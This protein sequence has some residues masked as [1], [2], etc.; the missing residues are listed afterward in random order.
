MK[1]RIF[2]L[3]TFAIFFFQIANSQ[4]YNCDSNYPS[5]TASTTSST[6][7]T[8]ST[9]I[10]G[11]DYSYYNV[12]MGETYTWT[13]CGDSDFD[14]QLTL[15]NT[16][17]G[18][19]VLDYSDDDC[20]TQSTITW[21]ATYT[22]TVALL[23]SQYPCTTNTTSMT[24]QWACT[25][26][27]TTSDIL[28]TGCTGN[29]YDL[30]GA[31]GSYSNNESQTWTFCPDNPG[32]LIS[33]NF[34][35]WDVE[36][37][38]NWD[39]LLVYNGNSTAAPY[40]ITGDGLNTL[41]GVVQATPA[42]VSGCLTFEWSSDGSGTA[43][44]WAATIS[45]TNPCQDIIAVWNGS[46]PPAIYDAVD[47]SYYIDIC[48]GETVTF[49]AYGN[50]PE[51]GT[52]YTQ[53]DAT[54]T[55]S[56]NFDDG[57]TGTGTTVNHTYNTEGGFD[58]DLTITD[59][60][61][62]INA[63]DIGVR[64]RVSTTPIFAGTMSN[65]YSICVG[66][67][68]NLTGVVT[69]QLWQ[70]PSSQ[71]WAGTT[72]LPDGSGVSYTTGLTFDEF[73]P[74][75]TVTSIN[76]IDEICLNMEHS[77][78]GDLDVYIEC[79]NG[80]TTQL[81]DTYNGV[82]SS[83]YLGE[84]TDYSSNPGVG[85]DYCFSPTSTN[86]TFIDLI[87]GGAPTYSYVDADGNT[88]TSHAYIPAGTYEAEGNWAN[89]IGC[90]LNGTWTIHVTDH[91]S[92]DDGYI[93]SWGIGFDPSLYPTMW[94]FTPTVVSQSW[95][96][97]GVGA[98][99]PTT[100]C[101]TSTGN[102]SYVYSITDN[103]G[104]TYDTT[105]TITVSSLTITT[106]QVNV[107]CFGGSNGSATVTS[108]SGG[109]AP[110]SYTWSPNVS[111][112]NSATGL[113]AGT[114]SV[115]VNDATGCGAINSFTIT[116]P[117]AMSYSTSTTADNCGACDG[118]ATV[119]AVSGGTAPYT[120]LWQGG[121]TTSP[122]TNLC[123]G[124]Y[125]VVVT[126]AA[127][128]TIGN[129]ATVTGTGS[130]TAG[131]TYNGNQCL[132]GGANSYC[133]T[134]TGT[135]G[136]SYSWNF[137][138]GVGTSTAPNPCYSYTS[139]GTYTVTQTVIDGACTDVATMN[140][141]VYAHPTLTITV[142]D[143]TCNGS[144]NGTATATPS[145]GSG[146][147]NYQWA[148]GAGSQTTQTATALCAGTYGIT[149]NDTYGCSVT[150]SATISEPVGITLTASS[151]NVVCNGACDGTA[152]VIAAGGTGAYVYS[153]SNSGST[154]N[155]TGLCPGTYTVSVY[156]AADLT[157]FETETVVITEPAAMVLS[158]S[159]VDATC[160]MS[161]GS[162]TVSVTSGG[163]APFGYLW[164]AAAGGQTTATATNLAA[165]S[166]QVVVNDAVGCTATTTV[167]VNDAGSPTA[168][169][170]STTNVSCNGLCDGSATVTLGGTLNPDFD[171]LWSTGAS[172][173]NSVLTTNTINGLCAGS[174]TVTVT[175]VNG[176]VATATT[177]ITEAPALTATTTVTNANCGQPDGSATASASGGTGGYSYQWDAAAANQITATASNLSA[178]LY[179]VV[180]TDAAGCTFTV[181]AN[182][183]DIGGMTSITGTSANVLCN[184]GSTGTATATPVGGT[185]PYDYL[186]DSNAANQIT[187]TA[188]GLAANTYSV[189]VTDDNG[190]ILVGS[191]TV[192]Q[193][194]AV[195]A[196]ISAQTPALCNGQASGTATAA[197][198][199]GI[200]PYTYQWSGG[201]APTSQTNTGLAAGTYSVTVY[202]SNL[203][204]SITSVTI[205][206][207]T[208]INIT[209]TATDENCF[210]CNGAVATS[211]TGGTN[212]YSYAWSGLAA[213]Q[214]TPTASNLCSASYTVTVTDGNGCSAQATDVVTNIPAGTATISSFHNV[215]CNGLCDGD[216]TVS[217]GG[218]T[219][220]YSYIWSASAGSQ[221]GTN[222]INLCA[223]VHSVSVTDN[224]GCLVTVSV[225]IT[226]PLV[227]TTTSTVTDLNCFNVCEGSIVA[228]PSGGT[229]PYSYQ[230]D[231]MLITTPSATNL[232]AGSYTF[233]VTDNNGCSV[234][235]TQTV[236]NA[237]SIEITGIVTNANCGQADG[238]IDITVTGGTGPYTY[239][240]ITTSTPNLED[241]T[242]LAANT[243]TV[244]V[245]DSK[246]C[247]NQLTFTV[248][249]I[250]GPSASIGSFTNV[251]CNGDCDGTATV[252]PLG[253]SGMYGFQ[254]SASAGSQNTITATNLCAGIHNITVTD[255]S[256][257]C[258]ATSTVTITE[259]A[260]LAYT[261]TDTDPSCNAIYG[262]CNGEASV[263]V[264]GGTTPYSYLWTGPGLGAGNTN[265]S[266][267]SLCAGNYSL[268]VSDANGCNLMQNFTLV[269][270]PFIN[271]TFSTIDEQCSG[272]CDG[273]ALVIP[274]GGTGPG[275]TYQW[276]ANAENQTSANAVGLCAG[277]Y[278]VTVYDE[279]NCGQTGNVNVMTPNPMSFVS[280]VVTDVNCF[281][282][283]N[284][285]IAV[286]VT[287]G[288]PPYTYVWS[289]GSGS[290]NPS[291]LCQGVYNLTVYDD[292]G[293]FITTTAIVNQPPQLAM[294]LSVTDETC[295][296][297]NDGS[298]TNDI[299]GGQPPYNIIWMPGGLTT[300][301]II[302]LADGTYCVTVTDFNGCSLT[303][304]ET[305]DGPDPLEI[306]NIITQDAH[307]ENNDGSIQISIAGGIPSYNIEWETG[308]NSTLL[309]NIYSG[310][311]DVT[312]TDANS[313]EVDTTI[314][315]N[316]IDGPVINSLTSS[317]ITCFGYANGSA[318]VTYTAI[319]PETILW[320]SVPPQNAAT[321]SNLSP[322]TYT[323]EIIDGNGCNVSQT[324]NITQPNQLNASIGSYT[325]ALC[326]GDCN[327][328]ATVT[329][330]GG[331]APY[332]YDWPVSSETTQTANALCFGNHAVIVTDANGCTATDDQF[333]NQPNL[334]TVTPTI[335]NVTCNGSNNGIITI[336]SSGS[337]PTHTYNWLNTATSTSTDANLVPG[338]HTVCITD[339]LGCDTCLTYTITQP[340][341]I[342]ATL[343]STDATC[344]EPNG[345]IFVSTVSGGTS[346][347]NYS[348]S[349]A[350][351]VNA[352]GDVNS[353]APDGNYLV[354]IYD[355]NNCSEV[356]NG[357]ISEV[358]PPYI[359]KIDV[360]DVS[361]YGFND[362]WADAEIAGG[363]PPY[364]YL[365]L[366]YGGTEAI[367][368][369]LEA[370]SYTLFVT[371]ATGCE[372][373]QTILVQQPGPVTLT[374]TGATTICIGQTAVLNAFAN[375][376][377]TPY[378]YYW[379]GNPGGN[380]IVVNPDSLTCYSVS[381]LDANG[382]P[383]S[384][385]QQ[386]C[387]DVYPAITVNV[388]TNHPVI[389]EGESAILVASATGG[390]GG[391]Y[392]FY[393]NVSSENTS[394]IT[395]SPYDSTMYVV[396]ATDNC[397]SPSSTAMVPVKVEYPPYVNVIPDTSGCAPITV[398]FHNMVADDT[399][400]SYLWT[401]N[402]P[403]SGLSNVST[404]SD[405]THLF[406]NPGNYD[407]TLV[408]SSPNGCSTTI[409]YDN[410]VQVYPVPVADF[411]ADPYVTSLFHSR[412]EF[413]EQASEEVTSWIWSF[414]DGFVSNVTNPE[415]TYQ[416]PG[417]YDVLLV[418]STNH[419]CVDS[420]TKEI[421]ILEEVTFYAP[422]AITPGNGGRNQFFY[423]V[424]NGLEEE[425]FHMFI[426][427][428]WGEVIF[429]TTD[430]YE[431]W[432]GRYNGTGD[433]VELGT[434]TW[435]VNIMDVNGVQHE[436]VGAVTVIR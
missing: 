48:A 418:V 212:P 227:L 426:Y 78:V 343:A 391:P 199:G 139:T 284:G 268:L 396:Y 49:N 408:A 158:G 38:G 372:V 102:M 180:V 309:N 308:W 328:T 37:G 335:T 413:Y 422:N 28:I 417:T 104:C 368:N 169:I 128:C 201:T 97:N 105:I 315:I 229:I 73:N 194:S 319:A 161:N 198:A 136:V 60:T 242:G 5:G 427:D 282:N 179:W 403:A 277:N 165:G 378:T 241:Q 331:T 371:D 142:T 226:E 85:Y 326:N 182:V 174:I 289:N 367:A 405:P 151:S 302:N 50:Y 301:S 321:A 90:P 389:C 69:P 163:T 70:Y 59:I 176:C 219:A 395:V 213:G 187:Q 153:W 312:I 240:W 200:A 233:T 148:A 98:G 45:C 23:V 380:N 22:G 11:G 354:T 255:M 152:Q 75:Q 156:D 36:S 216:A 195:V 238:E 16:T 94:D 223:G 29:F 120:Y 61:G 436:Y 412:I 91:L 129:S 25:S 323:V 406:L 278:Q 246:S 210:Q 184:G 53:S 334:F 181:S 7:T 56:W 112:G 264:I 306:V 366:P 65:D 432:N 202:D 106:S 239:W 124:T 325:N 126:D 207:P 171:Y 81:F 320:N 346:P 261:I 382:C 280:V 95:S 411:H 317:N 381:V 172:T 359:S 364:T 286:N 252:S 9:I 398:T 314:C 115:T 12:T 218:G 420:I 88:V 108:A 305:V 288:T 281:G 322:G 294:T 352:E 430:F 63:N 292:N 234:S 18:G 299:I 351:T 30:G 149:V 3:L 254:W 262:A 66:E 330:G 164:N 228:N 347:Y 166:Y 160:G 109:T 67:C 342:T 72:F 425:T 332:S 311:Y 224:V 101:P 401:F 137:G 122:A 307:C 214:T 33:V 230:W 84:A 249:D 146:T 189:T 47:G 162:A 327:G 333:I 74:G 392:D 43:P 185:P 221:T 204:P 300:P 428:R 130:V 186:W 355:E 154:A 203:C 244:V 270:P 1:K 119:G 374:A 267:S 52:S 237:D 258:I 143:A 144:C 19:T 41:L 345:S 114:Y 357:T 110:Y 296:G 54:S 113:A 93:F 265:S 208:A 150:G 369:N 211:V 394:S 424:G 273:E 297:Y 251:S 34:T 247:T 133:F 197:G 159:S 17:C 20:G 373:N 100:A 135:S 173:N 225:T 386:V 14:T 131:F 409:T 40:M 433:Y 99:N 250:D 338:T 111:S 10:Y 155:I 356:F 170:S 206:E 209:T 313:C 316:N 134:N 141:T 80:Q 92:A 167:N 193:P 407:V 340:N 253:G 416:E 58:V 220:P 116:Q 414:G 44:G 175:D 375:G 365:W 361:C 421:I 266:V 348:W 83:E 31:A 349:P 410:L 68:A 168:S 107:S 117:A 423:V 32:S 276:D 393:W 362:G 419:N 303:A 140:V 363:T 287:G 82:G 318:T 125:S 6:L 57:A 291:G 4:C 127:G 191:V 377:S 339:N 77:Y 147:Y 157:C 231:G 118:T 353:N 329:V 121:Q 400:V 399:G 13:T 429:E 42:N 8:V 243:Y 132:N 274:S 269:E 341:P 188:S 344:E 236:N 27:G 222:A 235:L 360:Y 26:C 217:I 298:I 285:S 123:A 385:P 404:L 46:N 248:G 272:A 89:L 358:A 145:G 103:F 55:F 260:A 304:C 295:Y 62:C 232:C 24:V 387:V 263:N 15:F 39:Q 350:F 431:K 96:G 290:Q 71:T 196:S 283:C 51:N 370:G 64:V 388:T 245:T 205:T 256:N 183:G 86:G 21:T 35:T 293:C 383:N 379:D 336:I 390:N 397:G 415:H 177:T 310:C 257:G 434:Y 376:G 178:G 138:D 215:S 190:C 79:P 402:D 279:N 259:P 337:N 275:Y 87:N 192:N 435:L 76:D 271:L 2:L 324:V 384:Q